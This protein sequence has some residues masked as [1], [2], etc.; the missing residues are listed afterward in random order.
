MEVELPRQF[1]ERLKSMTD[2]E[3]AV[4]GM[5][6]EDLLAYYEKR[7]LRDRKTSPAVGA[8]A[9]ELELERLGADGKRTGEYLKLS[10][11]RGNTRAI[12]YGFF[13]G[14]PRTNGISI[15]PDV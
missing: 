14:I 6:R 1:R 3:L 5:T 7:I 12:A 10:A 9:P 11:L 15:N 13:D 2:E 4:R 8:E